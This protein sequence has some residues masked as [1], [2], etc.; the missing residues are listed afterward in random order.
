MKT[1]ATKRKGFTAT[2][3]AAALVATG[4]V[5]QAE[6]HQTVLNLGGLVATTGQTINSVGTASFGDGGDAM[7][8]SYLSG[9]TTADAALLYAGGNASTTL[10]VR[11]GGNAHVPVIG[12]VTPPTYD[13]FWPFSLGT[14]GRMSYGARIKG[15]GVTFENEDGLWTV[16]GPGSTPALQLR[17]KGVIPGTSYYA[18]WNNIATPFTHLSKNNQLFSGSNIHNVSNDAWAGQ[19]LWVQPAAGGNVRL[20]ARTGQSLQGLAG[21]TIGNTIFDDDFWNEPVFND[22]AQAAFLTDVNNSAVTRAVVLANATGTHAVAWSGMAAP[23]LAGATLDNVHVSKPVLNNAGQL[24]FGAGLAGA[25]INDGN[26][27]ALWMGGPGS[28][29]LLARE[30]QQ[31]PGLAAGVTMQPV[32]IV[33]VND[34]GQAL[35]M[36]HLSDAAS[37]S[38]TSVFMGAPGQLKLVLREGHDAADVAAGAVWTDA[39]GSQI[40]LATNDAGQFAAWAGLSGSG[41]TTSNDAGIWIGDAERMHLAVREGDVVNGKTIAQIFPYNGSTGLGTAGVFNVNNFGQILYGA[42]FT[43]GT[44][45]ILKYTPDLTWRT[46]AS[47]TWGDY[48]NWTAGINPAQMHE[49][50]IASSASLTVNGPTLDTTVQKLTVGGGTGLN[51]LALSGGATLTSVAGT[52]IGTTGVLTGDGKLAGGSVL[53]NGKVLA[54]PQGVLGLGVFT[55]QGLVTGDGT[56][57]AIFNNTAT[58]K[59]Q[60]AVGKSL[61]FINNFAQPQHNAGLIEV[62]GEIRFDNPLTNAGGALIAG[63]SPLMRFDGGLENYGNIAVS[64]GV[65]SIFGDATNKPSGKI[66]ATGGAHVA[67]FDDVHSD[68]TIHLAANSAAVFLGGYTGAGSF[69]GQGT[70]YMEGDMRPGNSPAL[71]NVEGHLVF[72]DGA[73][74][75]FELAGLLPAVQH[76]AIHVGG[77]LTLDGTLEVA[78]IDGFAPAAGQSFDLL[79]WGTLHGTFDHVALPALPNALQ[80]DASSL[81]TS[82]TICVTAAVPEPSAA[83]LVVVATPLLLGRRRRKYAQG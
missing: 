47:G 65:A 53:N 25:G 75:T 59:V 76:D 42:S 8:S 74:V 30:G 62:G 81:Y 5:A 60:V 68:G 6:T 3:A 80:W 46:A 35:I 77:H 1:Q 43:D 44:T 12:P 36:S 82:G 72:G 20:L 41:V 73:G 17:E 27:G 70:A 14:G 28:L 7:F 32:G 26:D 50:T 21:A 9:P 54:T 10:V 78:L 4:L 67:L 64:G 37:S 15:T 29:T 22:Q 19:A 13:L 49:V 55:N 40:P 57:R 51:T 2:A 56:I 33:D 31:A 39:I 63:A 48:R 23:G 45:S 34:R 83:A 79:D 16:P 24:A 61:H 66:T 38:E 69:T 52:T 71:T 18:Q 11:E 58:G